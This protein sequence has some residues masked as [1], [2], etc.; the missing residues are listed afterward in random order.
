MHLV[1]EQP[2]RLRWIGA[3]AIA[4]PLVIPTWV[5]FNVLLAFFM[6]L[7]VVPVSLVLGVVV[8]SVGTIAKKL[9]AA[10]IGQGMV[11]G[12]LLG[13]IGGALSCFAVGDLGSGGLL[14]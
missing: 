4:L 10:R 3:G 12:A 2:G 7:I 14:G 1:A 11:L 8:W 9:T 5:S 6:L 13:L